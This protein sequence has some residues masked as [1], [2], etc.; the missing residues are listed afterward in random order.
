MLNHE[1]YTYSSP[2]DELIWFRFLNTRSESWYDSQMIAQ[3]VIVYE[4]ADVD[5]LCDF[6]W[7]A[8]AAV[9]NCR[10]NLS[11]DAIELGN[12]CLLANIGEIIDIGMQNRT[13]WPGCMN[14]FE[15]AASV[16]PLYLPPAADSTV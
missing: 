9:A 10:S 12:S 4:R 6:F 2:D 7:K 5:T 14:T 8:R 15:V 3:S 13:V 16:V 11:P 1:S